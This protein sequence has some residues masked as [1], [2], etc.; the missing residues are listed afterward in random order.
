[1][2]S[3]FATLM[4]RL[5]VLAA[6]G[7]MLG[8]SALAQTAPA[9]ERSLYDELGQQPGMVRLIDDLMTRL[10]AD[11]RTRPFF[12]DIDHVDVKAKMVQQFCQLAGGPCQRRGTD[13]RT[14]H[15]GQD[16]TMANFNAVVEI[17]QDTMEAEHIPFAIQ[18]RLLARIAP[19][20]REIVNAH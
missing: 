11:P 4:R 16:I 3:H 9:A 13:M 15:S 12:Q 17:L 19:M 18:N 6:C 8:A 2:T 14:A 20:H 10:V 1:M 5:G 7:L